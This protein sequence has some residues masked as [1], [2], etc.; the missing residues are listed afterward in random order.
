MFRG[1]HIRIT[2]T[3]QTNDWLFVNKEHHSRSDSTSSVVG[4]EQDSVIT[5]RRSCILNSTFD[6][7]KH[8]NMADTVD[9]CRLKAD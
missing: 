2:A 8:C 6:A 7:V 5:V 9:C 4:F 1:H 3:G